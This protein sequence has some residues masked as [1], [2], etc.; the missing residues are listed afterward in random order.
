MSCVG[1]DVNL[2]IRQKEANIEIQL[3]LNDRVNIHRPLNINVDTSLYIKHVV[4]LLKIDLVVCE[5]II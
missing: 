4:Q 2:N 1:H 3:S 5:I